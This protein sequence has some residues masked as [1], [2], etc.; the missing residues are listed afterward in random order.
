MNKSTM[1]CFIITFAAKGDI[2]QISSIINYYIKNSGANWSWN[3]QSLKETTKWYASH[4]FTIHPIFTAKT[5]E[6][7]VLGFSSLSPF[8]SKVGYWPVA[9]SSIYID[10][11]Y[12]GMQIGNK[13][14]EALINHA[15]SSKLEV[16]TAWID[17]ENQSSI[18]FHKN[19]GF[20]S[21]GEMKNIGDKWNTRRSVT[22]LQLSVVKENI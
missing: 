3:P 11:K 16:I 20:T 8:R 9:E 21:T 14:M 18:N 5:S 17:S 6:G 12:Q 13:L 2:S 22:I 15:Y 4:D 1:V 19:W 10:E 7:N